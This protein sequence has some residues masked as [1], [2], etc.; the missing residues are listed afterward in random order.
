M[1]QHGLIA[2][3]LSA[4][5][6]N[7]Y[8]ATT[9]AAPAPA[10]AAPARAVPAPAPAPASAVGSSAV[11]LRMVHDGLCLTV[12]DGST[13]AGA[14][15]VQWPCVGSENQQW[16]FRPVAKDD[17]FQI[18]NVRSGQ[19]LNVTGSSRDDGAAVIQWPCVD[20][21][22]ELWYPLMAAEDQFQ[23]QAIHSDKCLDVAGSDTA[24]GVHLEQWTCASSDN[25]QVR[26][27]PVTG[28]GSAP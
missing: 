11:F 13:D 2:I 1:K 14:A 3:V 12:A 17:S 25:Q 28:D 9:Q 16:V 22:N 6:Y 24:P 10:P 27:Q 18:V 26:S 21:D 5:T 19:C 8:P 4:C 7:T 15:I 20:S 23:L